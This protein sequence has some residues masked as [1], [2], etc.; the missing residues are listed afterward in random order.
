M[1]PATKQV[2]KLF[3]TYDDAVNGIPDVQG[4]VVNFETFCRAIEQGHI[5]NVRVGDACVVEL[6]QDQISKRRNLT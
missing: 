5:K 6:G 1:A 2:V 3:V 4:N